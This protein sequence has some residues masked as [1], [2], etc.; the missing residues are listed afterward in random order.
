MLIGGCPSFLSSIF[1]Y[2]I[3]ERGYPILALLQGW[4]SMLLLAL[5][6]CC[7]RTLVCVFM[8]CTMFHVKHFG[9]RGRT[10]RSSVFVGGPLLKREKWRTLRMGDRDTLSCCGEQRRSKSPSLCL[11]FLQTRAGHPSGRPTSR[12]AREVG[13]PSSIYLNL[14]G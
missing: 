6:F 10:G 2:C 1:S 13:H 5:T 7:V 11:R 8:I 4:A 12:N 9:I 3:T 14:K